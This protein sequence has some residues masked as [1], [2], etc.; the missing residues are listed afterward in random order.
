[1]RREEAEEA[2]EETKC[3]EEFVGWAGDGFGWGEAW[4][5]LVVFRHQGDVDDS[6]LC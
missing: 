2:E 4:K 1:M 3:V 5:Y 6:S